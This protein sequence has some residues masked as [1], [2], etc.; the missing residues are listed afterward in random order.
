MSARTISPNM[1]LDQLVAERRARGEDILHLGFGESRLPVFPALVE[2]L[3]AGARR[4]AYGPVVGDLGAR[5]AVAGWFA[6]RRL[7]TDPAQIVLAPGS[8]PLLM[9]LQ[10]AVPGDVVLPRPAW[11][12]YAPQATAMGKRVYRLAVPDDCGGVP[13]PRLLRRVVQQARAAGGDPRIVVLTLP[14]NPTG[15]H[16]PPALIRELCAIARELDLLI[17]SDEIYRD[18]LHDPD[19]PFL[20]PA[21]VAPE[22]TVVTTGL[23]K[24]L[25]LG[26]W[27]VGAARFPEGALGE[28]MCAAVASVASEVWSNLAGPMQE[29]AAYAFAE[30]AELSA[31][32]ARSTR[33]HATVAHAVYELLTAAGVSCRRPT[34]A[35]YLYPD[36]EAA[37]Q[38][39]AWLGVQDSA[40]LEHRFLEHAKVAVLGGHHLGDRPHALR[41]RIATCQ[42][43]GATDELQQQALDAADPL[44]LPHVSRA[45]SRIEES[46]VKLFH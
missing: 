23:S 42:L 43:Y 37:R 32:I 22:R 31:H 27:R 17:V 20:S 13:R 21:E 10:M 9:A 14:D 5:Q 1:A 40:S 15:T 6:R 29:V 25:A 7:P 11:N 2:R 19:A 46:L 44:R 39:L 12:T 3:T 16:A 33:L 36:M 24:N 34:G 26:G 8:K 45:L 30:P 38:A 4:S 35:F 18:V 41:F 28:E